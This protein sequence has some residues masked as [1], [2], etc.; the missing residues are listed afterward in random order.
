M[1]HGTVAA[2]WVKRCKRGPMDAALAGELVAGRGLAGSADQG[3]RRQVTLIEEEVWAALMREL[4]AALPT[5]ARRANL[6]VRGLALAG[7]RGRELWVGDCLLR[8]AGELK[9]CERM[10]HA[11]PGLQAAMFPD[12]RG[13]AFAQILEGGEIRVGDAVSWVDGVSDEWARRVVEC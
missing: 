11:A 13:G 1:E 9:P 3:G 8:I 4:G 12:W 6:V 5:G 2:I 10:E 7:S